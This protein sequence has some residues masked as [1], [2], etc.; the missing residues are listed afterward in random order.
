MQLVS[1]HRKETDGGDRETWRVIEPLGQECER[2]GQNHVSVHHQ[3]ARRTRD[4]NP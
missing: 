2:A 1:L 4:S 3:S